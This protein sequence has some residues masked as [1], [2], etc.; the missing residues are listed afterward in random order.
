MS[1]T[2]VRDRFALRLPLV[3][4]LISDF[5]SHTIGKFNKFLANT[6][7]I[8]ENLLVVKCTLEM[9]VAST[10]PRPSKRWFRRWKCRVGS[11]TFEYVNHLQFENISLSLRLVGNCVPPRTF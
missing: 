10:F 1:T 5:P 11:V 4:V 3:S 7:F 2:R 9:V 8:Y 6:V